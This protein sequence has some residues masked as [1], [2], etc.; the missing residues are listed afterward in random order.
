LVHALFLQAG[1]II[2]T[3]CLRQNAENKGYSMA[4]GDFGAKERSMRKLGGTLS[5]LTG[6][7]FF[8]TALAFFVLPPEL[9][10]FT[11]RSEFFT[12]VVANPTVLELTF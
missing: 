4:A 11:A 1:N 10:D 9:Q 2:R 6:V 8:A 3:K 7:V 12:S 5:V